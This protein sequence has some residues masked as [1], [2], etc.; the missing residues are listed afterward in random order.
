MAVGFF[1]KLG[2][3]II[4]LKEVIKVTV[5]PH[6]PIDNEDRSCYSVPSVCYLHGR[7]EKVAVDDSGLNTKPLEPRLDFL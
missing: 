4:F 1:K 6:H 7:G 5:R 2:T 3:E